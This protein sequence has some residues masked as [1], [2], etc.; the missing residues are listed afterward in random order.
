MVDMVTELKQVLH[1]TGIISTESLRIIASMWQKIGQTSENTGKTKDPKT[2]E[3]SRKAPERSSELSSLVAP[4]GR[5]D[6]SELTFDTPAP[7]G[8]KGKG[9]KGKKGPAIRGKG[10]V[11][12]Q[13]GN[14][15]GIARDASILAMMRNLEGKKKAGGGGGARGEGGF[16]RGEPQLKMADELKGRSKFFVQVLQHPLLVRAVKFLCVPSLESVAC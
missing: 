4:V 7:S 9:G 8:G 16:F 6:G 1:T 12:L 3:W 5:Q 15:N 11:N 2:G 10:G 13:M 14:A